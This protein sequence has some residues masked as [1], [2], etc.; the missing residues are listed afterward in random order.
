MTARKRTTPMCEWCEEIDENGDGGVYCQDC[1]RM[2]CYDIKGDGDDIIG[3]PYVTASGDLF[4]TRCGS[5]YDRQEEESWEDDGWDFS[6]PAKWYRQDSDYAELE[7]EPTHIDIGP[8]SVQDEQGEAD[9]D[10]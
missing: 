8:S 5:Q 2:L 7:D 9:D 3:H 6:Y 1:G 4:C 10:H